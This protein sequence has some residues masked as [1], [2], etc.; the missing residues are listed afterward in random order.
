[1][2][3]PDAQCNERVT[4]E[5]IEKSAPELL[6]HFQEQQFSSFLTNIGNGLHAR[7]CPG[8]ECNHIAVSSRNH[9]FGN[10]YGRAVPVLCGGCSTEFCLSCGEA[11]HA[12]ACRIVD[13]PSKDEGVH[14]ICPQCKVR[15]EK[16]GGC[17]HMTCR[18]GHEFCWLCMEGFRGAHFCGRERRPEDGVERHDD[19]AEIF[20]D[21]VRGRRN[22]RELP[23]FDL[24]YV[25]NTLEQNTGSVLHQ[26]ASLVLEKKKA[27]AHLAHYHARY[28]AHDQGQRYAAS[29]STDVALQ[30]DAFL[31]L[32]DILS[33]TDADF[34]LMANERLVT[35][36]RFLK[37]SYILAYFLEENTDMNRLQKEFFQHRQAMLERFTEELSRVSENATS[38]L[39]RSQVLNLMGIVEKC[40][41]NLLEFMHGV[42]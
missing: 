18:C 2:Q 1:M 37:Y 4:E 13:Q 25:C 39:D 5:E 30:T 17:N 34:L 20:G 8:T 36:R 7:S 26:D 22:I 3:C 41:M 38:Q 23:S 11:P 31:R 42:R 10:M 9:R 40:L 27:M 12:F 29:R 32:P 6:P 35:L 16:N 21:A 28:E 14:K 24:E 33:G 15:I 19:M